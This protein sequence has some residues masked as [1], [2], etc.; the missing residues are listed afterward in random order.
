MRL[1]FFIQSLSAGGAE[2]VTANLANHWARCGHVVTILTQASIDTDVYKLDS[3]VRRLSLETARE[4]P[5]LVSSLMNNTQRIRRLSRILHQE[6]PDIA[7]G[8]MTTACCLLALA[9]GPRKTLKIGTERNFPPRLP[10]PRHW[11]LIRQQSYRFLDAVVAQTPAA[12]RWLRAHTSARDI[13]TI[14]NSLTFPVPEADPKI[15][16]RGY[17]GSAE[18]LLL[19]V[20]SLTPQKGFDRLI[21]AFHAAQGARLGW[22]LIILG[23][24]GLRGP[25]TK[26]IEHLGLIGSVSLPGHA[27]NVGEWYECAHAFALSSLYEGFP[28]VLVEA[29]AYG[30]PPVS[31]DCDDGPRGIISHDE[32]GLIV[33]QNDPDALALGLTSLMNDAELRRA[34]G[35]NA[36]LVRE[37]YELSQ[38]AQRWEDLI[39]RIEHTRQ[40]CSCLSV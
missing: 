8:F 18:H 25:L 40:N 4:S 19:A 32:N 16:P 12:N 17:V 27:G 20:G 22:K 26:Q 31:V 6:G 9:R 35:E 34:L 14:P 15:D 3:S 13:S 33:P 7:I 39:S 29:M 5:A 37:R 38:I 23:E 1:L 10:L 11:Q 24:G 28:N 36:T 21:N 30:C 2:R